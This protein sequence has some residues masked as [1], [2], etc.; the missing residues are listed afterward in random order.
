L[1]EPVVMLRDYTAHFSALTLPGVTVA[2]D[3]AADGGRKVR[4]NGIAAVLVPP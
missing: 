4:G 1:V 3:S 2:G